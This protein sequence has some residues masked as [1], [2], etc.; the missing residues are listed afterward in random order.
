MTQSTKRYAIVGLGSTGLSCVRFLTSMGQPCFVI[1]HKQ[2][3][4]HLLQLRNEF[5]KST[6]YTGTSMT[7][8][9]DLSTTDAMIVS[10][11]VP[12]NLP[13]IQH[14]VTSGIP[15][16]SDIEL[17]GS[18]IHY[19]IVGI[20]GSN[21]KST[22]ATLVGAMAQASG[23][24]VNLAGNIGQPVLDTLNKGP[25]DLGILEFS[26]FQ[27]ERLNHFKCTISALLNVTPDHLDRYTCFEAYKQAKHRIFHQCH[28]AIFNQD[29]R[30]TW[31]HARPE[32]TYTFTEKT[33][34]AH[35]FGITQKKD[36]FWL[37]YGQQL[38][39]PAHAIN[40]HGYHNLI[41]AV[42][43]LTIGTA[44][45]LPLSTMLTVLRT[46]SGLPHR[47]QWVAHRM[48]ADWFNDSKGTN[49]T[50]SVAAISGLATPEK[51]KLLLIA[52]GDGKQACFKQL[53]TAIH[54]HVRIAIVLG[55][56]AKKIE[57]AIN[58]NTPV[59]HA[60]TLKDAVYQA[61]RLVQSG[62]RVLFSPACAS[63]DMFTNYQERGKLFVQY[64]YNLSRL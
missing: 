48:R 15:V 58:G 7:A 59:Y 35:Q 24:H 1:D 34:G 10:P 61:S 51:K 55:K 6:V 62:E 27:L 11:G 18:M 45:S 22:V 41:N 13:L 57:Y 30:H 54:R 63:T 33:P 26:S 9:F 23:R 60:N 21:G 56:D 39:L 20:T 46:F 28:T 4:S 43:A 12:L 47:C 38:L 37:M 42:T 14:A 53:A 49:E 19:P 36:T 8:S 2:H 25:F 5:P 17:F 32:N 31:P 16:I 40:I 3:P 50:A 52:G 64:V 44:L 29:D